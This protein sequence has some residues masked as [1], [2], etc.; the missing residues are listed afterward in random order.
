MVKESQE[1]ENA[2]NSVKESAKIAEYLDCIQQPVMAVDTEF[3]ILYMNEYGAK[4]LKSTPQKLKG[5]KC[6]DHFKTDD[7][8]TEN[9]ACG[10]AM[11]EKRDATSKTIAN[12]VGLEVP[13]QYTGAPIFDEKG[14]VVGAVEVVTN[15][16][17]LK[18]GYG[19][20]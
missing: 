4:L 14:S 19:N 12:P 7:C 11:R 3:N 16:T 20:N 8:H 2:G 13:I 6:Y 15:I 1:T 17:D 18:E 5:Q 9:C 10:K